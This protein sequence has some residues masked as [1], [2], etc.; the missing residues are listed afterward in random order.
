MEGEGQPLHVAEQVA[1]KVEHEA[2][3]E[4]RVDVVVNDGKSVLGARYE[5]AGDHGQRKQ[6]VRPEPFKLMQRSGER[7]VA[8]HRIDH[9][10]QRPRCEQAHERADCDHAEGHRD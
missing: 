10:R 5:Q 7:L 6:L 2:L 9:D 4:L 1:A 8:E 3:V